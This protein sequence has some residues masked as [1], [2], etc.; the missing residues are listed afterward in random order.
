MT[1]TRA[2]LAA[3]LGLGCALLGIALA[4]DWRGVTSTLRA[5]TRRTAP[6]RPNPLRGSADAPLAMYR[7]FGAALCVWGLIILGTAIAA[8][9]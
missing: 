4:V 7:A 2:L 8:L 1:P 6:R 5:S 9:V 3:A